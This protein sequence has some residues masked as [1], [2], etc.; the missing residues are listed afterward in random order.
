MNFL[1]TSLIIL[2]SS[3]QIIG[4]HYPCGTTS[5]ELDTSDDFQHKYN[6]EQ[7]QTSARSIVEVPIQVHIIG[8]N[9]GLFAIDTQIVVNEIEIMNDYFTDINISF[10]MC[11]EINFIYDNEL[12]TFIKGESEW[13][14]DQEDI[15]GAINI[16]YAPQLDLDDG[17]SICGYGPN[18]TNRARIFIDNNCAGNGATLTHEMGHSFSLNHT[19]RTADGAELASGINCATAGDL[20]CD[21]PADPLI[22]GTNV[23]SNCEYFGT[24]LDNQ[25]NPYNPDTG[26]IMSY[27]PAQC[28]NHFSGEQ[29][30]K[31]RAY[32]DANGSILN[33]LVSHTNTIDEFL[34]KIMIYPNP[35]S[36]SLFVENAPANAMIQIWNSQGQLMAKTQNKR[37]SDLI[38]IKE[39]LE[40]NS[41]MYYLKIY[42][43]DSFTTKR[44]IKIANP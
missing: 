31:M 42:Y 29:Y 10:V 28:V 35:S 24:E 3:F 32:Y 13:I 30:M 18:F 39:F 7:A 40:F 20:F 14:C 41:G 19:H 1:F 6:F 38:E 9:N 12:V 33:C 34:S 17:E 8:A 23:N 27:S 43:S 5:E 16:Y 37:N 2:I 21:T 15:L 44:I 11:G 26:N 25:Q 22:N 4:Q 36:E